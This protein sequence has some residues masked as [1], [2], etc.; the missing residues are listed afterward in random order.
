MNSNDIE[1]VKVPHNNKK[2]I[3]KEQQFER[4]PQLYLELLENKNKVKPSVVNK[5]YS[6]DD[7]I[8][9]KE[10]VDR[11][12]EVQDTRTN[13]DQIKEDDNSIVSISDEDKSDGEDSIEI[14]DDEEDG[15]N[16]YIGGDIDN[17]TDDDSVEVDEDDNDE[18]DLDD[19]FDEDNTVPSTIDPAKEKLKEIF[20][21]SDN[22][23]PSLSQLAKDG[24]IKDTG[25]TIP[26]LNLM[27]D[28]E[29][30]ENDSEDRKREL[31]FKFQILKKSYPNVD[32]PSNFSIH[33]NWRTMNDT[34]ENTLRLLQLD[35][36]VENYKQLLIALFMGAE[37]ILGSYLRFDMQGF[38]KSQI[39]QIQSYNRLLL[40]M[41][42]KNY[43]PGDK[44]LPVEIRLMGLVLMNSV[45][46]IISRLILKKTGT[47]L[48][49]L[50]NP[51]VRNQYTK[52]FEENHNKSE[53]M[54]EYPYS[55]P[56]KQP[57]P[58]H[59]YHEDTEKRK[60]KKPSFNFSQL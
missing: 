57:T 8:S 32:I 1:V 17:A 19:D 34:Y 2:D 4:Y 23:G 18:F 47:N 9:L 48:M 35:S 42:E 53:D 7:A 56:P 46:F 27:D 50:I 5:D 28:D 21:T 38:T 52:N 12:N 45:I 37:W 44:M 16:N 39:L 54:H 36:N 51:Q 24:V 43:V 10:F 26:N 14:S 55:A 22:Q 58:S 6:P 29:D 41:G 33:S 20:N 11:P 49:S 3:H 25:K 40:E 60:M 15:N 59:N 13:L 30:D 31:L